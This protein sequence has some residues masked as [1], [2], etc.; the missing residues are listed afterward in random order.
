LTIKAGRSSYATI[1]ILHGIFCE[2]GALSRKNPAL[3][4]K[5]SDSRIL[6]NSVHHFFDRLRMLYW[7]A[8]NWI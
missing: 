7:S 8:F 6:Y 5:P 3:F 4:R 1:T 2:Y